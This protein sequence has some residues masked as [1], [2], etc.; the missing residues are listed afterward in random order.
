MPLSK[1]I[2]TSMAIPPT[3][4]CYRRRRGRQLTGKPQMPSQQDP[5]PMAIMVIIHTTAHGSGDV[6]RAQLHSTRRQTATAPARQSNSKQIN[7]RVGGHLCTGYTRTQRR[8]PAGAA[9]GPDVSREQVIRQ[10]VHRCGTRHPQW[11]PAVCKQRS[12]RAAL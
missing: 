1:R 5:W 6:S 4:K 12:H 2:L 10:P 7:A 8:D 9:P 11:R 3:G